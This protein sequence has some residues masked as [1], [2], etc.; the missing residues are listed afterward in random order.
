MKKREI[1][2]IIDSLGCGGAE[3]SLVA[4]LRHVDISGMNIDLC[5]RSRG[6]VLE[7]ELPPQVRIIDYPRRPAAHAAALLYSAAWRLMPRRHKAETLWRATSWS[8]PRLCK[9][10]DTAI[11]YQQGFPTF[12]LTEK[13]RAQRKIAWVNSD[14]KAAGY[15]AAMCRRFYDRCDCVVA[16]SETLR[17]RIAGDGFANPAK[18][19]TVYDIIDPGR[20][21]TMAVALPKP[22]PAGTLRIVTVGRMAAP[23]NYSLAVK[24][25][26]LLRDAGLKF[27]WHFVGGG[28]MMP[29][30]RRETA[31]A[32]L[33]GFIVFEGEQANPYPWFA[34][35][36]IYVQTSLFEGFGLTLSEARILGRPVVTTDFDV[37]RDQIRHGHNGIIAGTTPASVA[38][39]I[40]RLAADTGL[41]QRIGAAAA[42]EQNDTARTESA[43]IQKLICEP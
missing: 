4:M 9:T 42:A 10:Y 39:A 16:V 21:R 28:A 34:A 40:M 12:F 31:E 15:N 6:G 2:I 11:A 36:D 20:I 17:Q 29:Q 30:I 5:L 18:I 27:K 38:D 23:K 33:D 1:L 25:A 8:Y 19:T 24:A 35:A 43:K 32:G 3:K 13:V 22:L 26:A 7:Q 14:L 41:R 37:A